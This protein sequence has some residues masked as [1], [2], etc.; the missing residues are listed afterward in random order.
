V[1]DLQMMLNAFLDG[2]LDA[3]DMNAVGH[4]CS[5]I[6]AAAPDDVLLSAV[7]A[8]QH[9]GINTIQGEDEGV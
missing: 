6:I 7:N 1:T 3:D 8:L 9:D 5:A 4:L 2:R